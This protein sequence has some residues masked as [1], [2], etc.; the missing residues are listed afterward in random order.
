MEYEKEQNKNNTRVLPFG[1]QSSSDIELSPT[2]PVFVRG[3]TVTHRDHRLSV[4]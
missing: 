3:H 1:L 4:L 2:K